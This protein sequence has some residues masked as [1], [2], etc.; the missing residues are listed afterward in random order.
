MTDESVPMSPRV[1]FIKPPEVSLP[2]RLGLYTDPK[3]GDL[4]ELNPNGWRWV[5]GDY[6]SFIPRDL[7]F[8]NPNYFGRKYP[9]DVQEKKSR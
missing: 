3:N 4:W 6:F 7:V 1:E 5:N 8:D 2:T 9:E